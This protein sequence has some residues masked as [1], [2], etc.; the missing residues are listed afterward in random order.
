MVPWG[1][2]MWDLCLHGSECSGL[3]SHVFVS[4]I[5]VFSFPSSRTG[6]GTF[7]D[8]LCI[9]SDK[10]ENTLLLLP[11]VKMQNEINKGKIQS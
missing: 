1:S 9:L 6:I 2:R 5:L 8:L 4:R 11:R 10:L 7:R 3:G